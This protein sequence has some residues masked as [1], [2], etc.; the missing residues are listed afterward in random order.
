MSGDGADQLKPARP[1]MGLPI[2]GPL[3][4]VDVCRRIHRS[5]MTTHA[6]ASAC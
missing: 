2:E 4:R 3:M 5:V 1:Q 6:E